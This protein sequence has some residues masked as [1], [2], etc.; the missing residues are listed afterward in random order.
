[1]QVYESWRTAMLAEGGAYPKQDL[2]NDVDEL[3]ATFAGALLDGVKSRFEPYRPMLNAF[4]MADPRTP[5][6]KYTADDWDACAALCKECKLHYPS[7][8]ADL[9]KMH[10]ACAGAWRHDAAVTGTIKKNLLRFYYDEF[11]DRLAP[12][13]NACAYARCV[14]EKP[15]TSVVVECW[16]SAMAY[17]QNARRPN[18]SDETTAAIVKAQVLTNPVLDPMAPTEPRIDTGKALLHELPEHIQV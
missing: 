16:F 7:V 18:L 6:T 11:S 3:L 17:N 5:N 8:K 2:V 9:L 1:M 10:D 4:E 14:F 12:F 13:P 15:V